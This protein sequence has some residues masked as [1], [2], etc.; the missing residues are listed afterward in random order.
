MNDT[1]R[2]IVK[3]SSAYKNIKRDFDKGSFNHAY[4]IIS[5]DKLALDILMQHVCM[6][7]YCKKAGCNECT[8]CKKILKKSKPDIK[9]PN[10]ECQALKVENIE[11]II[12]D[13]H[14]TSFE[15]GKKVYII[16]NL[17]NSS[18]RVQNK[19]L[20]T[21]E[22]PNLDVHFFITTSSLQG[23]LPTIVS[24]VKHINLGSFADKDIEEALANNN[25]TTS[26]TKTIS[27][28]A[29]GSLTTASKLIADD[30]YF[31]KVDELLNIFVALNRSSDI[32]NHIYN[33]IFEDFSE[34]V[35]IIELI[36]HDLLLLSNGIDTL[37]L[38]NRESILRQ[39]AKKYNNASI[40]FCLAKINDVRQKIR[41]NCN[42]INIIDSFFL[43]ILE[44][45][46]RC[47]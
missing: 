23:V 47:K 27:R 10:S 44:V 6:L 33:P 2:S 25:G 26:R 20:K 43:E 31:Q 41:A 4:L 5:S 39:I 30:G 42:R 37:T 36:F 14:M 13:T 24:R 8:E 21:L 28:C 32:I 46:S 29:R 3:E 18:D 16:K 12:A 1:F 17:E 7:I 15:K 9:E 45:K 19:L 35:D 11:D 38:E 40:S 22:E 34:A